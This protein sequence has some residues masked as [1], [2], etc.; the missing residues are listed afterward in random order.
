MCSRG[1]DL[2]IPEATAVETLSRHV[3]RLLERRDEP[4]RELL[5]A[6]CLPVQVISSNHELRAVLSEICLAEGFKVTSSREFT[7]PC[8]S[9]AAAADRAASQV[10]TLWDIPVLE[11]DWPGLLEERTQ[12]WPRAC[13]PGVCR[14]RDGR[15]GQGLRS[16]GL[17]GSAPGRER[18]GPRHQAGEPRVAVGVIEQDRGPDRAGAR[19]ASGTSEPGQTRPGR[20]PSA[21]DAAASVVSGRVCILQ[22]IMRSRPE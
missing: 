11:P 8:Q 9:R 2:A 13:P 4:P 5:A 3:I 14:S 21:R 16:R 15:P 20:D 19:R 7:A 1:V 18:S 6:S 17:P 12:S 10:L 22:S